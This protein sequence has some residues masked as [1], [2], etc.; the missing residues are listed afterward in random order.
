MFKTVK[1]TIA[2]LIF[3]FNFNHSWKMRWFYSQLIQP[4]TH[5]PT[6]E[7][8]A[9]TSKVKQRTKTKELDELQDELDEL[10][11]QILISKVHLNCSSKM[12][13]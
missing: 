13:I 10:D 12:F 8:T 1:Q 9:M 4:A 11:E 7:I 5:Q 6:R 3:N 2:K